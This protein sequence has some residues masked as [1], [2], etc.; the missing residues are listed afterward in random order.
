[1]LPSPALKPAN[2]HRTQLSLNFT[3]QEAVGT[4]GDMMKGPSTF[5]SLPVPCLAVQ[6]W[7]SSPLVY[8][9]HPHSGVKHDAGTVQKEGHKICEELLCFVPAVVRKVGVHTLK[10]AFE[11][12]WPWKAPKSEERE[13]N[14]QGSVSHLALHLLSIRKT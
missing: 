11:P 3:G 6:N 9:P 1:M 13:K 12:S 5:K 8:P 10:I 4:K 2:L 14:E 7:L